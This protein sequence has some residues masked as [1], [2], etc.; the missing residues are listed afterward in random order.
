MRLT[1]A[2]IQRCLPE[3]DEE[4]FAFE[5]PELPVSRSLIRRFVKCCDFDNNQ[6]VKLS[7]IDM[8]SILDHIKNCPN[9][10]KWLRLVRGHKITNDEEKS[11][12]EQ[13]YA[14]GSGGGGW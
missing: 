8:E 1:V 7:V 14:I 12:L 13:W 11:K 5:Y 2:K 9:C 6:F 3:G 4:R 10:Q